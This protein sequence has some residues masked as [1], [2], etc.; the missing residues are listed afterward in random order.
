MTLLDDFRA[1]VGRLPAT[2]TADR[3]L[4][5]LLAAVEQVIGVV[6]QA[7][8]LSIT[9]LREEAPFTL[10]AVT[11]ESRLLDAIQYLDGG[12]CIDAASS[13]SVVGVPDMAEESRWRLYALAA[14]HEGI[15]SSLSLP[16]SSAGRVVGALNLYGALPHTFS[17]ET[18]HRL[19]EVL[20]VTTEPGTATPPYPPA[21]TIEPAHAADPVIEQAV[22]VI[23]E[24]FGGPAEEARQ[25]LTRAAE[26]AGVG[27]HQLAE[28]IR[29]LPGSG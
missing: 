4:G 26:R 19:T 8:G 9:L 1:E 29:A 7:V 13:D 14:A 17:D 11:P 20:R 12:P 15:N 2:V 23:M 28:A 6:P 24:L 27:V 22:G 5:G 10:T 25:R 3:A 21:I 18:M 16:L